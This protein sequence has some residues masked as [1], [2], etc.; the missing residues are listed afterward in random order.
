MKFNTNALALSCA[1]LCGVVTL[2]MGLSNLIWGGYGQQFLSL[3]RRSTPAT[4]PVAD[5]QRS[6]SELSTESWMV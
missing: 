3:C 5:L 4:T 1:I 6:L 2:G